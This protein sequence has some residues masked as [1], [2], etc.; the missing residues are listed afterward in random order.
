[1]FRTEF[2]ID[3]VWYT[4]ALRFETVGPALDEAYNR[5]RHWIVPISWRVVDVEVP[6]KEPYQEG[7]MERGAFGVDGREL[8]RDD[9][10]TRPRAEQLAEID[11][12]ADAIERE[13]TLPATRAD[14]AALLIT[15]RARCLELGIE[16]PTKAEVQ[17]MVPTAEAILNQTRVY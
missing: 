15:L 7:H 11:L 4:N 10:D 16:L 6:E 5:F 1:M 2:A 12:I 14:A 17:L 13:V 8:E 3:G 9:L